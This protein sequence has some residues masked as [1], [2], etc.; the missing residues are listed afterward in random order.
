MAT[1]DSPSSP[2]QGGD[3]YERFMGRW[4]RRLVP[5]FLDWVDMPA[6][7]RWLDVGCGTGALSEAIL[8]RCAPASVTGVD[9]SEG[10]LATARARLPATVT[11]HQAPAQ[12]LPL[13]DASVDAAVA[14]LVLNFVPDSAAALREMARVTAP[15]GR[16]AACVWDYAQRMQMLVHYW[17]AA[18][19]LGLLGSS[20]VQAE[21]FPICA[22]DALGAAFRGAGLQ[23]VEVRAIEIETR[24]ADFDDYWLPFLGGQ[25]I[26]PAHAMRQSEADRARL[27]DA[28]RA[29]LPVQ[30]DGS[31]ALVARAWAA[32][33]TV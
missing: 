14:S 17:A 23:H 6:A 28:I 31:I 19:A 1:P 21:H 4:S 15:G 25:G 32:R 24:F 11:L 5:H 22:P 8:A 30:P 27:R 29:G 33:G 18:Q 16:V 3:A 7:R 9:P 10:F 12:A 2:W 20:G 13:A 26:A